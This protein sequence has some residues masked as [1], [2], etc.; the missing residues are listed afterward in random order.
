MTVILAFMAVAIALS[1]LVAHVAA[2]LSDALLHRNDDQDPEIVA[3][4][5]RDQRYTKIL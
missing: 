3:R 1:L 5:K 4:L 2:K